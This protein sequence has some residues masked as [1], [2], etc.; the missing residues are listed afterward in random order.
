MDIVYGEFNIFDLSDDESVSGAFLT[1]LNDE[2]SPILGQ[3][4]IARFVDYFYG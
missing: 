1:R 2:I 3:D 4:N